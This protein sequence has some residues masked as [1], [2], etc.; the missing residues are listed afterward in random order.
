M[1]V[2]V[3]A[4]A[5]NPAD[6]KIFDHV[7]SG[8]ESDLPGF[9]K[10]FPTVLGFEAAG[11]VTKL[12]NGV[13]KF[14]VGDRIAFVC[15]PST[16]VD[17]AVS[18]TSRG[19]FQQYALADQNYSLK[20]SATADY[21]SAASWPMSGN[22]AAGALYKHLKLKE[23]W[24]AGGQ[25]AYKGEK[26]VIL[27]GSSSIGAYAIQFAV[28]SG[29]DVITTSSPAHFDYLKSLGAQITIDRSA[30]DVAAQIIAAAGGLL[31]YGMDVI[32]I[33]ST[34]LLATEVLQEKG[35]LNLMHHIDRSV[36]P[37][38]DSKKI[39]V[40]WGAGMEG[41]YVSP[42]LWEAAEGYFEHG[43]VKY[44]RATVLSG[45]LNAWEEAFAMHRKGQVSGTKLIL[46]PQQ[47][48]HQTS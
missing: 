8:F 26:I 37:A 29:F 36:Q 20:L 25:G 31:K 15:L 14:K 24:V 43:I 11:E 18:Y 16:S 28:L 27:G 34:Q 44:N 39:E 10:H 35:K 9:V 23:P 1:Q 41:W 45:G 17:G 5:V 42:Q 2:R 4:A 7:S 40:L 46:A 19:A 3:E 48:V 21:A 13:N 12:G 33:A 32:S 38:I 22:T 30:P 47:T 6:Y